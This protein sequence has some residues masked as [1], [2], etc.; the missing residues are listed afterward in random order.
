MCSQLY[1]A[2][3]SPQPSGA[4]SLELP[5]VLYVT[6]DNP[7]AAAV[8]AQLRKAVLNLRIVFGGGKRLRSGAA[9]FSSVFRCRQSFGADESSALR[10]FDRSDAGLAQ[11]FDRVDADASGS[12]SEEEMRAHIASIYGGY[13]M[14]CLPP[15]IAAQHRVAFPSRPNV[16]LRLHDPLTHTHPSLTHRRCGH[17]AMDESVVQ[18]MIKLA[19]TDA[20]GEVS[21]DEFK[22]IM[23]AGPRIQPSSRPSRPSSDGV[24]WGGVRRR[25]RSR[26]DVV[27]GEAA[28]GGGGGDVDDPLSGATHFLLLLNRKTFVGER[29]KRLAHTLRAALGLPEPDEHRGAALTAE[30]ERAASEQNLFKACSDLKLELDQFKLSR[31]S[32]TPSDLAAAAETAAHR[33]WHAR[34][35]TVRPYLKS[36]TLPGLGARRE[37]SPRRQ[38]GARPRRRRGTRDLA[39]EAAAAG[40]V[41]ARLVGD[42]GDLLAGAT[43]EAPRIKLLLVH[44]VDTQEDGCEF[45]HFFSVTPPDL[46]HAGQ[47]FHMPAV[48]LFSSPAF[49]AV[50]IE[51]VVAQRH[52]LE[53]LL[54]EADHPPLSRSPSACLGLPPGPRKKPSPR[55]CRRVGCGGALVPAQSRR[56]HR[57]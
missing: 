31:A 1:Y 19:D 3:E 20:D 32:S 30:Q 10:S 34:L 46:I 9:A 53:R 24:G 21:L 42:L 51:L 44:A 27:A 39:H 6:E 28:G 50:S 52:G 18:D 5:A 38:P 54:L 22:V 4:C 2:N 11:A 7:G 47:L 49:R 12:I 13:A 55:G 29:G 43:G 8:A 45:D 23:R 56:S 48:P 16:L 17:R 57:L 40:R 15:P 36:R 37:G 41:G 26:G 33:Q 14:C 35:A 25:R